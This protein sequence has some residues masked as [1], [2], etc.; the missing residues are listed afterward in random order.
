MIEG[1]SLNEYLIYVIE[2][3][4]SEISYLK[5]KLNGLEYSE[6]YRDNYL[7]CSEERNNLKHEIKSLKEFISLL[8]KER[9]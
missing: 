5:S 6:N 4:N 2:C 3:K 7:I 1:K 9:V 8:I